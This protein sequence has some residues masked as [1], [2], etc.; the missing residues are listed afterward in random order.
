M[1]EP[2]RS[3]SICVRRLRLEAGRCTTATAA[4]IRFGRALQCTQPT[5]LCFHSPHDLHRSFMC[6]AGDRAKV[7]PRA[8]GWSIWETDACILFGR[9]AHSLHSRLFSFHSPQLWHRSAAWL[10]TGE[11]DGADFGR[12]M[13][14][15]AWMR[16]GSFAQWLHSSHLVFHSPQLVH[17]SFG[18]LSM[19]EYRWTVDA[20]N[21]TLFAGRFVVSTLRSDDVDRSGS[22][23]DTGVPRV[24]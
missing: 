10:G 20:W 8:S 16:L 24:R 4:C 11:G 18:C 1:S 21:A 6:M 13:T 12:L 7:S 22:R 17:R 3:P 9:V 2:E 14:L 23:G 19:A 15:A 5:A